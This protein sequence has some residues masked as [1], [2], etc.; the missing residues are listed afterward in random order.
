[1]SIG[2]V[3]GVLEYGSVD[4]TGSSIATVSLE[5]SQK[6]TTTAINLIVHETQNTGASP[7]S[8]T[9]IPANNVANIQAASSWQPD[10]K[11]F[12]INLSAPFYGRVHWYVIESK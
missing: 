1:M 3:H 5:K 11:S 6:R 12:T 4:F 8:N 2:N 7:N 10:G 9:D